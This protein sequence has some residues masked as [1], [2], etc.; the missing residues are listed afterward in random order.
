MSDNLACADVACEERRCW[1]TC[2]S[3]H[4]PY[5]RRPHAHYIDISSR[6]IVLKQDSGNRVRG[7][8]CDNGAVVKKIINRTVTWAGAK[9]RIV[10]RRA[11]TKVHCCG[12][13]WG[14]ELVD[15]TC[16]LTYSAKGNN[17]AIGPDAVI[18]LHTE[19]DYDVRCACY[20]IVEYERRQQL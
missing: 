5:D 18:S 11:D 20:W 15:A 14:I 2:P 8:P 3:A 9:R 6:L 16:V 17:I 19:L 7:R 4:S 13:D 12:I 10:N 1:P